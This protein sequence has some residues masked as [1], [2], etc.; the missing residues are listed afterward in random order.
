MES[1]YQIWWKSVKNCELGR[2]DQNWF[3]YFA[4][5][6]FTGIVQIKLISKFF[7]W[8]FWPRYLT[9][10]L[11]NRDR[12]SYFMLPGLYFTKLLAWITEFSYLNVLTNVRPYFAHKLYSRCSRYDDVSGL[13]QSTVEALCPYLLKI[14]PDCTNTPLTNQLFSSLHFDVPHPAF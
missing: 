14:R 6:C 12:G 2:A 1:L 4:I 8:K 9:N 5:K 13:V 11:K 10:N 7:K 3:N